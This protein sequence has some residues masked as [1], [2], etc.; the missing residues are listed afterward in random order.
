V[1]GP[2]RELRQARPGQRKPRPAPADSAV[3]EAS[4]DPRRLN[5]PLSEN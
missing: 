4:A 2:G 1:T 3:E 5:R